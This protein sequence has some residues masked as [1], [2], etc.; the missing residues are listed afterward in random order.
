MDSKNN[1][2]F[3]DWVLD[4]T[5]ERPVERPQPHLELPVPPPPRPSKGDHEPAVS[6]RG[7]CVIEV[8]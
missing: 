4:R 2:H 3:W 7:V 5:S 6:P 8:L 1:P